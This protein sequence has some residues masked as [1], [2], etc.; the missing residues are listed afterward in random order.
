MSGTWLQK[1]RG[2]VFHF[3]AFSNLFSCPS[4]PLQ[5]RVGGSGPAPRVISAVTPASVLQ[6]LLALLLLGCFYA[7]PCERLRGQF[8]EADTHGWSM[9]VWNNGSLRWPPK[10]SGGAGGPPSRHLL[11]A[12]RTADPQPAGASCSSP[13]HS[14]QPLQAGPGPTACDIDGCCPL[15]SCTWSRQGWVPVHDASGP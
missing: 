3:V 14:L 8:L 5:P 1:L 4:R 10:G 9:R 12:G 15:S 7:N 2:Y 6:S 13:A 11:A